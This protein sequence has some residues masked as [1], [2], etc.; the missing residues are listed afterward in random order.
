MKVADVVSASPVPIL[1]QL[2]SMFMRTK[3]GQ[4]LL[5]PCLFSHQTRKALLI[6]VRKAG[7]PAAE[8]EGVLGS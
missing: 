8:W 7:M 5:E 6:A 3:A 2:V 1:L 4:L